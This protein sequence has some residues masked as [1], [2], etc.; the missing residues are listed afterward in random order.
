M[1]KTTAFPTPVSW[2]NQDI[3]LYHGTIDSVWTYPAID[4]IQVASKR[5]R[6]DFGR[7]F[8]TTTSLSQARSWAWTQ[9]QKKSKSIPLVLEFSI[10]RDVLAKLDS[11][12]FVRGDFSAEDYWILVCH[13]RTGNDHGRTTILYDEANWYDVVVGPLA[14]TWQN[15]MTFTNSDQVSFHTSKAADVLNAASRSIV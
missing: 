5:T 8:Y 2:T 9:S 4:K 11:V 13:C 7:G 10:E 6:M 1:A 3:V 14:S 12:W 15:R